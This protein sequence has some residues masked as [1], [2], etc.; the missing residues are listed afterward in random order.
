[1]RAFYD[2]PDPQ[3]AWTI[4]QRYKAAYVVLT[5]YERLLMAPEGLAKFDT[6]VAWGWLEVVYDHDGAR[7]YRV[8]R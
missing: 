6:L 1:V 2:T 3:T 5:P 8:V 7:L 4:L